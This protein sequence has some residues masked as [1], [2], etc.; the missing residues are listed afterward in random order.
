MV[1]SNINTKMFPLWFPSD[2]KA[3]K[4]GAFFYAA[5]IKIPGRKEFIRLFDF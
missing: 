5:Q 1:I 4:G 2:D 3:K